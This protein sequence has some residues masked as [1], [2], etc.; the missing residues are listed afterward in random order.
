[1][2]LVAI[3]VIDL[4]VIVLAMLNLKLLISLKID[5]K[6]KLKMKLSLIIEIMREL[7]FN[8]VSLATSYDIVQRYR[9]SSREHHARH[10]R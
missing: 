7:R 1:M 4:F 5:L 8:Y 2:Y 10:S 3:V 6:L 9:R